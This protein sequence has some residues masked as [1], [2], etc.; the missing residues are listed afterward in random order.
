MP[1]L[2]CNLGGL[3]AD[4]AVLSDDIVVC[5]VPVMPH[6]AVYSVSL[7]IG[8]QSFAM[9]LLHTHIY[10]C[11]HN[12]IHTFVHTYITHAAYLI[13]VPYF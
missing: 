11:M 9:R 12:H 5:T 6:P 13:P 8:Q 10:T 2:Q 4:T 7:L 3:V 1:K